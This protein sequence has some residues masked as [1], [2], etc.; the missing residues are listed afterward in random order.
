[1]LCSVPTAEVVPSCP[2]AIQPGKLPPLPWRRCRCLSSC[3]P[4]PLASAG[5]APSPAHSWPSG[6][7]CEPWQGCEGDSHCQGAHAPSLPSEPSLFLPTKSLPRPAALARAWAIAGTAS[8]RAG[9]PSWCWARC[10]R[11]H[12][13][14]G[15]RHCGLASWRCCR[16]RWA[17]SCWQEVCLAGGLSSLLPR[18]ALQLPGRWFAMH[19]SGLSAPA[20]PCA[21]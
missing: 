3:A 18:C 6:S 1:M 4:Q 9:R 19:A 5:P 2:T 8:A 7:L 21:C 16:S 12:P 15:W 11:A 20:L 10:G 14:S 17:S 13:A